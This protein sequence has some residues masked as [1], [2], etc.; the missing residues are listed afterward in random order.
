MNEVKVNM[1]NKLKEV[2]QNVV[3]S[4]GQVWLYG[5]RARGDYR[6]KSDWD[7]LIL[8]DQ[9][10]IKSSD[11]DNISFPFVEMGWHQ[12][13]DISPLIYT[14]EEWNQREASPFWQNVER[15]KIRIL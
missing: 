3:P 7:L 4:G 15:E 5:S 8:V 13:A 12:A 1:L 9:P 2:A 10:H 6:D 11:E 14:F